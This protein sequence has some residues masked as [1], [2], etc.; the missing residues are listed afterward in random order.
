[1]AKRLFT[2]G[3]AGFPDTNDFISAL[4]EN[5]IQSLI[6]VRSTPYC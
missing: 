5:G 4:K 1:M 2:I 3:Y 6:D